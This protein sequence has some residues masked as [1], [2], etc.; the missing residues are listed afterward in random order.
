MTP[1]AEAGDGPVTPLPVDSLGMW[2]GVTAQPDQLAAAAASAAAAELG[3]PG[4]PPAALLLLGVGEADQVARAVVAVAGPALSVPVSLACTGRV[5]ASVGPGTLVL[6]LSWSGDTAETVQGAQAARRAGAPVVVVSTGGRLGAAA[7]RAGTPH[8]VLPPEGPARSAFGAMT[9]AVLVLLERAGLWPGAGRRV[10]RAGEHL[11]R[12]VAELTAPGSEAELL[13]RRIDRTIPLVHGSA[14]IAAV[15]AR[16][17]ADQVN[18]NAKAPAFWSALPGL[19]YAELAGWGQQGDVT[20]QVVT[21]VSLRH[22]GET[23]RTARAFG[24]VAEALAEVVADEL[25]VHA[26]GADDL[27]RL[28]DLSLLGDLVSLHLAGRQGV[29]PGPVPVVDG[30]L[31]ALGPR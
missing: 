3:P 8:V 5:P 28:L 24:L 29:D 7:R 10:R 1:R 31:G 17:W 12:R 25:T 14:G 23:T 27:S 13:A 16:R 4:P 22:A 11:A 20:R 15:A 30:V 9:A 6:A 26:E 19:A 18:L 2:A 21:M